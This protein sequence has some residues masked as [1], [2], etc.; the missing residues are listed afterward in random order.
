MENSTKKQTETVNDITA[1]ELLGLTKKMNPG[2]KIKVLK[3]RAELRR[4]K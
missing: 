3:Y 2:K 4:L 1:K